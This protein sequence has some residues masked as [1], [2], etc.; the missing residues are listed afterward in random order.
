MPLSVDELIEKAKEQRGRKRYE[1]A[2]LS[3]IAAAE[4]DTEN[5]EAWWQVALCRSALGDNKRTII[6]L[7]KTVELNQGASNA[8]ARLGDLL[9]KEEETEEAKDAFEW[10]LIY[11]SEQIMALKGMSSIYCEEN[12]ED[13]DEDEISVLERIERLSG[14]S[15]FQINRFG[16]LHYRKNRIH[17]AIRCW[18]ME[19]WSANHPSQRFNLG[20]AYNKDTISQDADAIDMWRLTLRDWPD[21]EP[22]KSS[23]S[24]V[25]PRLLELSLKARQQGESVLPQDQWF[26]HYMNPFQLLNPSEHA[27]IDELD[28]KA[29]QKLKKTLM[30]EIELEDGKVSW[31]PGVV[32]DKSRAIG[33]CDELNDGEK[34]DWHWQVFSN[35]PLLG[36]LTK[37]AHEHFLVNV[38]ASELDTLD[39]IEWDDDFLQWLG[40]I[41]AL[42]FDRVLTKAIDQGNAVLVECLLDGRRWVPESM[43]DQCF[44]NA[45]RAAERLLKPLFELEDKADKVKPAV[46]DL[47]AA[48]R[49][50]N[51]LEIM[52]LLPVFFEKQQNDAVHS[53]RGLAVKAFNDHNDIDLSRQIIECAKRFKFRSA[54][55]NKTIDEDVKTIEDLIRQERKHEAKLAKGGEDWEITKEGVRQGSRRIAAADITAA[56]W[57]ALIA[58]EGGSKVWDFVIGFKADDG[59][60]LV[61]QWKAKESD[62][63]KHSGYFENLIGAALNYVFPSLME[64]FEARL[65]SGA[66]IHIG[67]CKIDRQGVRYEVKGWIFSSEHFVP[68]RRVRHSVD[69]GDL[70]VFDASDTKKRVSFSVRDTDNAHLL[71]IMVNMKNGTDD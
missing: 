47:E 15:K 40:R 28:P 10:A 43:V 19:V 71:R 21:Y 6:A 57:G 70:I 59:R 50:R 41:F 2:L 22:P 61:F 11:D 58:R 17:E 53:V 49:C 29:I 34:K 42:Q 5:S 68:W 66:S 12:D 16:V 26:D 62:L 54:G 7:R 4:Q 33:L 3:A 44:I 67:P 37:G 45:Q 63:E 30:Q 9:L 65:A 32:I 25:L 14:L 46:A 51:M 55:A 20:L 60:S 18:K 39:R 13:Q 38:N 8:W 27:D 48:F 64:R 56:R 36:F 69:N 35:K 1:E 52:N 24:N 23:I 31:I